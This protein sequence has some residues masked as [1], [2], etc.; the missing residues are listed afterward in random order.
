MSSHDLSCE[1][2]DQVDGGSSRRRAG[3]V[4]KTR[5]F[6]DGHT[7][8]LARGG[9]DPLHSSTHTVG[10]LDGAEI[11]QEGQSDMRWHRDWRMRRRRRLRRVWIVRG[12]PSRTGE[13]TVPDATDCSPPLYH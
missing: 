13:G 9:N 6:P 11:S 7:K 2:S 12:S 5:C 10:N 1:A 4:S 8:A 3:G